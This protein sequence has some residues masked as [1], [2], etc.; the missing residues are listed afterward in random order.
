MKRFL[1]ILILCAKALCTPPGVV[2]S[3]SGLTISGNVTIT[4]ANGA[5]PIMGIAPTSLNFGSA[6]I[7]SVNNLSLTISNSGGSALIFT[8]LILGD[9]SNYSQTNTCTTVLPATSCI[10]TV[11]FSPH[12][13]A[14]LNTTLTIVANDTGSPHIVNISGIGLAASGDLP[15]PTFNPP[16]TLPQSFPDPQ[17]PS[18]QTT[19]QTIY[20]GNSS[21]P[22][23]PARTNYL[24]QVK[25]S[26]SCD[27]T[28]STGAGIK[29][30][31]TDWCA[32]SDQR[33]DVIWTHGDTYTFVGPW[34]WCDKYNGTQTTKW[35]RFLSDNPNPRGRQV[36]SHGGQDILTPPLPNGGFRNHGCQ[37]FLG[38]PLVT[39][40]MPVTSTAY[41]FDATYN[42]LA[43]MVTLTSNGPVI[44][45]GAASTLGDPFGDC[46]GPC[47]TDGVNHIVVEDA[48]V[49]PT[50]SNT[51]AIIPVNIKP[52]EWGGA[53]S[54]DLS[55]HYAPAVCHDI[56]FDHNYFTADADDDGFGNNI[57]IDE[58]R[59]ACA[60]SWF[61][62]NYLDG[63]KRDQGEGHM[64][65]FT[66]A[67]GPVQVSDNWCEG[68]SICFWQGGAIPSIHAQLTSNT[69]FTRN[70]LTF[71]LR[72]LP[73][74]GGLKR[75]QKTLTT[76]TCASNVL[77]L[78]I[79][80]GGSSN[81][82]SNL[83]V[84][85]KTLIGTGAVSDGWYTASSVNSTT[86]TIPTT[87]TNGSVTAGKVY[88][89]EAGVNIT[90]AAAMTGKAVND[91]TKQ[92]PVAKNRWELKESNSLIADG[93]ICEN[94]GADGQSGVCFVQSIRAYSG[95]S[96][97]NGGQFD[98]IVDWINTNNIVR[99][100]N[101]A[102]SFAPRSGGG[103]I[104][105][106]TITN[107][108]CAG[109][110]NSAA[111]TGTG[112]NPGLL[113]PAV[114]QT[115]DG[116]D[117]YLTSIGGAPLIVEGWYTT[118]YPTS[119]LYQNDAIVTVKGTSICAPAGTTTT[120]TIYGPQGGSGNGVTFP[121]RRYVVQN[122]LIYNIGDHSKFDGN[123]SINM[124]HL[125]QANNNYTVSIVV[126]QVSPTLQATATSLAIDSCPIN[127]QCP[128]VFQAAIGDFAYLQCPNDTRFSSGPVGSKGSPMI[129]VGV[130]QLSFV[131]TPQN[132]SPALS[133]GNTATCTLQ[134]PNSTTDSG[135][136]NNQ[137]FPW[138]LYWNHNTAVGVNNFVAGGSSQYIRFATWT[139]SFQLQPG[140]GEV[141]PAN[142]TATSGGFLCS[143]LD[144][145][146]AT[147]KTGVTNCLDRDSLTIGNYVLS[148]RSIANY[149]NFLAGIICGTPPCSQNPAVNPNTNSVPGRVS[150]HGLFVTCNGG[151]ACDS[152]HYL[153]DSVGFSGAMGTD[154][155]PLLLGDFRAYA[156]DPSSPYKKG[157][158][159]QASDNRDIGFQLDILINAENRTLYPCS[160]PCGTGPH[161]DG[162]QYGW[163]TWSTTLG[164]VNYRVYR[165]GSGT[166]TATTTNTFYTDY[167]LATGAHTWVVK[168][169]DGAVETPV[170]GLST[171]IY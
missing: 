52:I 158:L 122:N 1:L 41:T 123:G 26:G 61:N 63:G 23:S 14:T 151:V 98:Q 42:D 73:S 84:Y 60:N 146:S 157:G 67:P 131:Y 29:Q 171:T 40:P 139:N 97:G 45:L 104:K 5:P 148:H 9:S 68:N 46:G 143:N 50:A 79:P 35:L 154:T 28:D 147:D 144:T 78:S 135:Y 58:V 39:V 113:D 18:T 145:Y 49:M 53:N 141:A 132:G 19:T 77:T 99:S 94:S 169:F 124:A 51:S 110:G 136:Y 11:T 12:S 155:F 137:S 86:V 31:T 109:D 80:N 92:A 89:Y 133:L 118:A 2:V 134:A 38:F 91:P 108:V 54:S 114:G 15:L 103:I 127:Q 95:V 100:S 85:L 153:P 90:S 65:S 126:N 64:V 102:Y 165:D 22:T 87:C 24:G 107:I 55:S 168:S 27:Y 74:P 13:V 71:N 56:G 36:C 125:G 37:G 164:A 66:D 33:W 140:T 117:V 16:L 93:N 163:L 47:P 128:K 43:N 8:S 44:Q 34:T 160:L 115:T 10:V 167:G 25:T 30:V 152:T 101:E 4:V 142:L 130:D 159:L 6:P 17:L 116:T 59:F 161:R 88:G 82:I 75:D 166:P 69:L 48:R 7:G 156:L 106:W 72:W 21:C 62:H 162:P 32:A 96:W 76:G 119:G 129:S 81:V 111:I 121:G 170:T 3:S 57:I 70:R 120:G 20:I 138:P 112:L 83:I 150:T 149:P 105:S